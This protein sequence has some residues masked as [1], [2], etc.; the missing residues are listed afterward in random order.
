LKEKINIDTLQK[1]I[2]E[3]KTLAI[4]INTDDTNDILNMV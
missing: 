3:N 2:D 1:I 4:K